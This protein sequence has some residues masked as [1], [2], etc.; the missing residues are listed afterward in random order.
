MWRAMSIIPASG[1]DLRDSYKRFDALKR[2]DMSIGPDYDHKG[3]GALTACK[4]YIEVLR[5][6]ALRKKEQGQ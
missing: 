6:L 5:G 4:L 1:L 2:F 3:V